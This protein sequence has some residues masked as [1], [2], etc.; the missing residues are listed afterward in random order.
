MRILFDNG[1]PR[2]IAA[3]LK[4]HVV[5]EAR[6]QGWDLLSNGELL[7]AAEAMG[8]DVLLTTDKNLRYQQNLTNRKIAIVVLG[9][10]RWKL[11]RI[12]L[13]QIVAIVEAATPGT[14]SGIDI[15]NGPPHV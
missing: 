1:T 11:I 12:M 14:Y 7:D 3:E 8:F 13:P 6:A 9:K 5:R 2:G 15:T 10:T 4:G